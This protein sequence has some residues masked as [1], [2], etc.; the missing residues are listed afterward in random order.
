[1][2]REERRSVTEIE[3]VKLD[4]RTLFDAELDLRLAVV[5]DADVGYRVVDLEK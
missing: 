1:M 3:S 4:G 2:Q 5:S